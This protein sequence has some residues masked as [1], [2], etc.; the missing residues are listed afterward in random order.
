[1]SGS[2]VA[3]NQVFPDMAMVDQ[4][5]NPVDLYQF[6]GMAVL[7]DFAAGWCGPCRTSAAEAE[8]LWVDH[9]ENGFIII[10]AILDDNAGSQNPSQSFL[11]G[12]AND[13]GIHFPV[14]NAGDGTDAYYTGLGG[15]YSAGIFD[16]GIPFMVLLDRDLRLVE[17]YIGS[18]QESAISSDLRSMGL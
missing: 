5:G 9:R 15:L 3:M 7:I 8:E 12:W 16:G 6:Y 10:H 18:G 11:Q 2:T 17:S 4:F 13:Y 14:I 1:M